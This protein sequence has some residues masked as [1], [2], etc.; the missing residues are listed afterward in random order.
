MSQTTIVAQGDT[1]QV[2]EAPDALDAYNSTVQDWSA[3]YV[4]ATGRASV[5]NYLANEDD[6][7][8]ETTIQGWRL[9]S[10]DPALFN[11]ILPTHRI[12]YNGTMFKVDAPAVL[13]RLFNRNH[14]IEVFLRRVDG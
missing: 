7:D 8:R 13:Y 4:V 5:Q 6:V 10:D 12:L 9:I 14:H 11:K 1:I 3:S 2:Y